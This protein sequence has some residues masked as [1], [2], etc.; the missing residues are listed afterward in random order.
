M[1]LQGDECSTFADCSIRSANLKFFAIFFASRLMEI[2][3]FGVAFLYVFAMLFFNSFSW[4]SAG[5]SQ[6][7]LVL[8]AKINILD[9]FFIF[10]MSFFIVVWKASFTSLNFIYFTILKSSFLK[11]SKSGC[12]CGWSLDS[13]PYVVLI[14]SCFFK[15]RNTFYF[16]N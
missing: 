1:V 9:N 16:F 4:Y 14:L 7:L 3:N 13:K 11:T 8:T 5:I 10:N 12:C 2:A 6:V 15:N